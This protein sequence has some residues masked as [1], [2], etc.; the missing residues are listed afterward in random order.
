ML[1]NSSSTIGALQLI[2]LEHSICRSNDCDDKE[3][4]GEEEENDN[5]VDLENDEDNISEDE[6]NGVL[7][8]CQYKL[9]HLCK[10]LFSYQKLENSERRAEQKTE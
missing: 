2:F 7:G 9:F 10:G 8:S 5:Q 6:N 1:M 3:L 4:K